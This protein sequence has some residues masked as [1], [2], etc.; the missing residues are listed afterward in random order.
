M[1]GAASDT[2]RLTEAQAFQSWHAN[3]REDILGFGLSRV[4]LT[5]RRYVAC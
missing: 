4:P 2:I 1:G 5:L 3:E